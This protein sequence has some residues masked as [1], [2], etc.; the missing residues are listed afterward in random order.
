MTTSL[1]EQ[2]KK[3][4]TPQT[5]LL[6]EAKKKPSLLFDPTEASKLD[7][8]VVLNIGTLRCVRGIKNYIADILIPRTLLMIFHCF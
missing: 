3:L 6:L 8:E 2:L 5:S 4:R 7:R 1:A